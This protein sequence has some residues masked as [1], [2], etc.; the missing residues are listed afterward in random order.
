MDSRLKELHAHAIVV[1]GHN[2][3]MMELAR[4]RNKGE[5]AVF[6][7]HWAP[8]FRQG[9]VNVL[10]TNVGG[11]NCSLTDDSDLLLWGSISLLDMLFEEAAESEDSMTVCVNCDEINAA[12][13]QDKIAVLLTMEGG[14]PL[15]GKPHAHSLAVLR[16]FYRQGLRGLQLVD[17]GRNRLCDGKGEARADGG[18][19]NFG[20]TVV[21]EMNRLGMIID[22]AHIT[23]KGFWDVIDISKDPIIDSHSNA[24]KICD[25]PRNLTDEQ[26]KALSQKGGLLGLTCNSAMTNGENDK[27]TVDDLLNHLDYIVG[28][29]GVEHVALGPDLIEPHNMLTAQGWL[30][31]VYYVERE[32]HY[33]E[34]VSDVTGIPLI[35]EAL[36]KRGYPDEDIRKVLGENWLRIYREIIG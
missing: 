29:V 21:T 26:I 31:G 4:R 10:M 3:M 33:I 36:I 2:H 34:G 9:G 6:S 1:D 23:E 5:T 25:H 28:L 20:V 19:T 13:S 18:L 30:E 7:G 11:D 24:Q 15:E 17:N 27:P 8:M 14:R 12:L 22:V 32:S 16:N 35:T